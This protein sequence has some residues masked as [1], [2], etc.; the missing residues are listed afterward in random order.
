MSE[1][2]NAVAIYGL[3][4]SLATEQTNASGIVPVG[5]SQTQRTFLDADVAYAFRANLP[6]VG[7]IG[8]VSLSSNSGSVTPAIGTPP[9]SNPRI[10]SVGGTFSESTGTTNQAVP[11][12]LYYAGSNAS[13]HWW[14]TSKEIEADWLTS[15][16]NM[17]NGDAFALLDLDSPFASMFRYKTS[18]GVSTFDDA[19]GSTSITAMSWLANVDETGLPV[20]TAVAYTAPELIDADGNDIYGQAIPTVDEINGLLL[21]C[22]SGTAKITTTVDDE[23]SISSNG[24]ILFAN[25]E[26]NVW[27]VDTITI[28]AADAD[29]A[30]KVT[31][32]GKTAS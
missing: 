20:I 12:V 11:V 17:S 3:Q 10:I 27:E 21:E 25:T 9:G 7:D 30:V 29:T 6:N 16:T 15:A 22:V 24:I 2:S 23:V 5:P 4:A 8:A 13:G 31:V 26:S 18:V 32:I 28:T 19:T 1:V 14:T